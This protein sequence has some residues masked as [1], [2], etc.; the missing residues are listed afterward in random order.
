LKILV[1]G[2]THI[3]DWYGILPT[4]LLEDAKT[5]DLVI[6][7][8]DIV[9]RQV[10]DAMEACAPVEA[11]HGNF[12][13]EELKKALPSK[14]VLEL[15]GWRVGITHGHLGKGGDS[16]E[17]SFSLFGDESLDLVVH[18]HTHHHHRAKVGDTLVVDPGSPLDTKFT[19]TRSYALLMLGD[20]I[21]VDFVLLG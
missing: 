11:V 1:T 21:D 9:S 20:S 16:D 17:K 19:S 3:P 7:A 15:D 10:I 5:S 12:C 8:G 6:L 2:D 4:R 13:H 14:K 18:G